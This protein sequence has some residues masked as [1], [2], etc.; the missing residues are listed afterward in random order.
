MRNRKTLSEW[1][2]NRYLLI[3]R[4]EENFAERTT[5]SFTYAKGILFLVAI[6]LIMLLVSLYLVTTLLAAW[7]DPRHVEVEANRQL[8]ELTLAVDS[9]ETEVNRKNAFIESFQKLTTG[10]VANDTLIREQEVEIAE[11]KADEDE[12]YNLATVDSVLRAEFEGTGVDERLLMGN[13]SSELQ[14]L[15]FIA[16]IGSGLVTSAYNAKIKHLGIDIVSK[17][18]EPIKA[19][20]D[21]TVLFASWTQK[22]GY[23]LAIQHRANV[24]TL[25][26]HNSALL[27]EAGDFV[28]AGEIVAIIGNTGELTTGPHLHFELWYNGNPVNPEEF[29]SF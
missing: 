12:L 21:G 14:E 19:A 22:E 13:S 8:I 6:F 5:L 27:K 7:L 9:L 15:Y 24:V 25:Y 17:Q 28:R 18:N 1:L 20:A 3:L 11:S 16:P 23:V 29:V 2:S 4:N 26:K 10:A